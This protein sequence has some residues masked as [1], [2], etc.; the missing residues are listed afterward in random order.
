MRADGV[1]GHDAC[2]ADC[3]VRVHPES[4]AARGVA[5]AAVASA[6]L[7]AQQVAA[8][9]ARDALYLSNH[10]IETL[11][12]VAAAAA[13]ASVVSVLL[14]ARLMPRWK[15]ARLVPAI[16]LAGAALLVAEWALSLGSPA[17]ASAAVY[18]HTAFFGAT[19][20][21]SFWSLVNERFDPHAAKRVVAR[22][23]TGG[24]VGGLLGGL[25]AWRAAAFVPARAMLLVV[26][27]LGVVAGAAAVSFARA[28]RTSASPS[29][30]G[31]DL[32][33]RPH[34][35]GLALLRRT[36]YLQSLALLIALAAL[37]SGLLDYLVGAAAS[38][39][40]PREAELYGFFA[41]LHLTTSAG[42]LVVQAI[43]VGPVLRRLGLSW[44][45]AIARIAPVA[46]VVA[47]PFLPGAV[48]LVALRAPEAIAHN[49]L[50]RSGYE[51]L[52][53]PL[54]KDDKRSTKAIID[55]GFDR[56]GTALGSGLTL[57]VLAFVPAHREALLLALAL[58]A[59]VIALALTGRVHRGYV[60]ALSESLRTGLLALGPS[61]T[62]DALTRRTLSE[63]FEGLDRRTVLAQI[64]S[65]T[66]EGTPDR[67]GLAVE[68]VVD[69]VAL[70]VG[71]LRS[72]DP[73]RARAVL[74]TRPLSAS[75]TA[76]ILPWLTHPDL[77][78]EAAVALELL[79][80]RVTGQLVDALVDGA[81]PP[82]VRRRVA[83]LLGRSP[84]ARAV[85]GLVEGLGDAELSVRSS[86]ARSLL[87]AAQGRGEPLVGRDPILAAVSR[88]LAG[89]ATAGA[90]PSRPARVE[91]VF[92]L[93]SLVLDREPLALA[94]R[95]L[96]APGHSLRGTAIEYL[97]NVLPPEIREGL[98][99]LLGERAPAR[100]RGDASAT[101][102]EP[103]RS[104]ESLGAAAVCGPA[105][106]VRVQ[107]GRER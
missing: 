81:N 90:G 1:W 79:A 25:I 38:S 51:L 70:A 58:A 13:A 19:S 80:P 87:R 66:P 76:H 97:D 107:A 92:A 23:A 41:V 21:S 22:I 74:E 28:T 104:A 69:P 16:C 30:R 59:S 56:A 89:A 94:R 45:V 103:L 101:V 71:A 105:G 62:H 55:V 91:H 2:F 48:G 85:A 53:T 5:W 29:I 86:C 35:T 44:A 63:S 9:P 98:F 12:R 73:A 33:T 3:V 60:A 46:S 57:L 49:S 67:R 47:Y 83:R 42:T 11:P 26:A 14:V 34:I 7:V 68:P 95:A 50:F 20:I 24:G 72:G 6:A 82:Q 84:G 32:D 31:D 8:K 27:A 40:H 65:Q 15:P 88:E 64:A 4:G 52:Y 100:R 54:P 78:G 96:A 75:L 18:I 36:P 17:W 93:L 102:R 77:G 61:D 37:A 43:A 99:S 39:A 10:P 106:A